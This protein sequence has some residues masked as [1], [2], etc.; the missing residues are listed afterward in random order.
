[1][2]GTER[3]EPSGLMS[4]PRPPTAAEPRDKTR[5]RA[6]SRWA[7]SRPW[8]GKPFSPGSRARVPINDFNT[9]ARNPLHRPGLREGSIHDSLHVTTVGAGDVFDRN[10]PPYRREGP[11]SP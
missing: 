8:R 7:R 11:A 9:C 6:P 4:A 3:G 10:A 5:S 2:P 1:V